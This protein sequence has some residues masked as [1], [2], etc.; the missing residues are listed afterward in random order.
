MADWN[1]LNQI[2]HELP[3][4]EVWY[5]PGASSAP[6]RSASGKPH[7]TGMPESTIRAMEEV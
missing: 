6:L 3:S 7:E 1:T 5:R 2:W 4:S